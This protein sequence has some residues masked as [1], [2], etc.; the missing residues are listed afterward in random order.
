MAPSS[1][2]T[3]LGR[4]GSQAANP[5]LVMYAYW[6]HSEPG[7]VAPWLTHALSRAASSLAHAWTIRCQWRTLETAVGHDALAGPVDLG[8][9]ERVELHAGAAAFTVE[10]CEEV[11]GHVVAAHGA[12]ACSMPARFL[13][14]G[15][16][17]PS[18]RACRVRSVTVRLRGPQRFQ[19]LRHRTG[20]MRFSRP[21]G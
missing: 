15:A 4:R 12:W 7:S 11:A 2:R 18:S 9:V 8:L 13:R 6:P 20:A 21:W 16:R 3:L 19:P 1:V 14:A 5:T 17:V 10:A